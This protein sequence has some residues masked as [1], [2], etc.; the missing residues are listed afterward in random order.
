MILQA[1][2]IL[3]I[4]G[5]IGECYITSLWV[6]A[7]KRT[8]K[9]KFSS[10]TPTALVI[11][12]CKGTGYGFH[13]N[14]TA[15]LNLEY[16][17]YKLL[18]IVDSKEDPAYIALQR[19]LENKPHARIV[20]TT[21]LS[22]CSGKVAAM[23]TGLEVIEDTTI[24]VF[25][26]SDIKP[27]PHWLSNIITPLQEKSV[28]A[29]TGYRWYFPSNWKTLLISAWNMASIVFMFYP[30]YT[31]A[32]GG[33]MAIRRTLFKELQIKEK[34]HTAFS[35]DL[36]LTT[37]VK[38]AGY[39]IFLQPKCIM[40]SPPETSIKRFLRWGTRQYT[41][42]RW[43]YPVFWLG[44]FFGFIGAQILILLGVFLLILGYYMPGA[45]L[46]SLLIFEILYGWLGISMLPKTMAYPKERYPSVIGYA[47]LTP[48]VF[49]FLAHNA[50]TSAI[51]RE[52]QWA[53]RT[54]RKPKN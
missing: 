26:D 28:G 1:L 38:K 9:T 18:F 5:I 54:Y 20:I 25:A 47:L 46:S 23:L 30:S 24:L 49:V 16:P 15:F 50:F 34:W 17:D 6:I 19:L 37:T 22:T 27:D 45:I 53:G 39:R 8:K 33:S 51:T 48:V 41:W 29:V 31:F 44:S 2:M 4:I 13:E 7:Y 12:P 14:I 35:D 40:E 43:Y 3:G 10:Y 52:L 21:P 36:V 42:V 11:V 32:W